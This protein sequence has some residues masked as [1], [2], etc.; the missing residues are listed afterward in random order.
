VW[1]KALSGTKNELEEDEKEKKIQPEIVRM[2][3]EIRVSSQIITAIPPLEK[4]RFDLLNQ[5]YAWHSI[6]SNQPRIV[7][8]Q[9]KVGF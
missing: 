8:G 6:A 2:K 9:F 4:A 1:T 3:L 5:F 7:H